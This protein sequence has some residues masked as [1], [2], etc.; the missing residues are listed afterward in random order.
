MEAEKIRDQCCTDALDLLESKW[1]ATG[2]FP[3]EEKYYKSS[4]ESK[5]NFSPVN[6]GGVNKRKMNE[7]ITIDALYV[8]KKPVE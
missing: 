6:W 1:L 3:A 8:L 7:W 4:T 5:P 2:G